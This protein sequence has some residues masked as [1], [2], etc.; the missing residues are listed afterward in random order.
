M[1]RLCSREPSEPKPEQDEDLAM[2]DQPALVDL[3]TEVAE[4]QALTILM[5]AGLF[6]V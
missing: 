1:N 3:H 4:P 2:H 6:L 5:V